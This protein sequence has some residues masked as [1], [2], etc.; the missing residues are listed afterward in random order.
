LFDFDKVPTVGQSFADEIFRV[1]HQKQP[2]IKLETINMNE[3]VE[4][5]VDRVLKLCPSCDTT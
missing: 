3:G 2:D 5:M 1:F 4:F